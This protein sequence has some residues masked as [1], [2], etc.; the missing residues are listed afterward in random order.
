MPTIEL[1]MIK[2]SFQQS[3]PQCSLFENHQKCLILIFAGKVAEWDFW[4]DFQ[5]LWYEG[6]YYYSGISLDVVPV[7]DGKK[8]PT[9]KTKDV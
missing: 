8:M 1:V 5:T 3:S 7:H 6:M 4:G 9:N 2:G